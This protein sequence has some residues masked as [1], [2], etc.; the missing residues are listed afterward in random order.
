LFG[1]IGRL[2]EEHIVLE[3]DLLDLYGIARAI[4]FKEVKTNWSEVIRDLKSKVV[5]Y[6]KELTA[7]SSWEEG[8]LFPLINAYFN[9]NPG[10]FA[11]LE[12]EHELAEQYLDAFHAATDKMIG[13]LNQEDAKHASNYLLLAFNILVNHFKRDEDTVEALADTVDEYGY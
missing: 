8:E 1:L 7:H 11:L 4:E 13:K 2:Q 12:Q 5:D 3:A 9:E 6:Q 10:D